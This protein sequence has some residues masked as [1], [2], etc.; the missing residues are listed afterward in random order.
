MPYFLCGLTFLI[1]KNVTY[2]QPPIPLTNG[3]LHHPPIGMYSNVPTH[4]YI[5]ISGRKGPGPCS[6]IP[7]GLWVGG[8]G[9]RARGSTGGGQGGGE[10][11]P[12]EGRF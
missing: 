5:P 12:P 2:A 1:L 10:T 9:G 8:S 11:L 4:P 7:V 3:D 6:W